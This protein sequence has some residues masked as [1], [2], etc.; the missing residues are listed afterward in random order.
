MM[1]EQP[2]QI[3]GIPLEDGPY[4]YYKLGEKMPSMVLVGEYKGERVIKD[5]AAIQR[6]W[7]PGEFFVGPI[8]PPFATP[9]ELAAPSEEDWRRARENPRLL[10]KRAIFESLNARYL[11]YGVN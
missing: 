5:G 6:H 1:T 10:C 9:D 7:F 4:W 2:Q 3:E 8:R 11:S